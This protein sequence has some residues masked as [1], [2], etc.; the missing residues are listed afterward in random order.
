MLSATSAIVSNATMG[1]AVNRR[2][3]SSA[4]TA[5]DT[6]DAA[7][8][9]PDAA[10]P[11]AAQP[12]AA[13]TNEDLE[14]SNISA[15]KR[16]TDHRWV[17]DAMEILVIWNNDD[18]TWEPETNLHLDAL[19]ALLQYWKRKGGRPRNPRDANIYDVYAIKK[20]SKDRKR[21]QVEWVGFGPKDITWEPR[22]VIEETSADI[23]A[24]YWNT[25]KDAT[26]MRSKARTKGKAKAKSRSRKGR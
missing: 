16:F 19:P 14:G 18:Q 7:E 2:D 10:Q 22:S 17:G 5:V 12:D 9:A 11:D 24:A 4:S 8:N 25:V 3:M 15:F 23:V 20:H 6:G 13:D 1:D 26:G 21:L